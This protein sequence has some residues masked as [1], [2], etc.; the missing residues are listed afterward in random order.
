MK[1]KI[2]IAILAAGLGTRMKSRKAK[3][4][5]EAGGLALVEHVLRSAVSLAEPQNIVVV[6]G[7]QA[8]E[9][10]AL[11]SPYG[12]RFVRQLDQKG[13]GH[14][15]AMCS[16]ALAEHSGRLIVLYGDCPLLSASTLQKL[17]VRHQQSSAAATV[18]TTELADPTGYGRAILDENGDVN[19]IVEQR[20]A[21]DDQK[22]VRVIN[23]G[24]YCFNADILWRYLPRIEPNP[25]SG[26]YYL[27]DIVELLNHEGHRVA[28]FNHEDAAELLGINT[29]VEL[30]DVDAILN[31]RKARE[32]MLAG[33]TIRK[34]E[35]VTL[36]ARVIVGMD[37]VI[38]PFAQLLGNTTV[39]EN[40]RIGA[41]AVIRDSR[42]ADNVEIA[43]YT[44]VVTSV[45]ETGA[46]VG[47]FAR[48]RMEN[49]VEAGAHIGNF[50][51][52]KKTRFRAGAKAGHLAYL[53]DSDIGAE[54]NIGAGTITCNF[55]GARKHKTS[56]GDNAFIGS[57]STL[58]APVEIGEGAY[59]GAGSVITDGVPA[60]ALALGRSRQT[61][62]EGWA[63]ER[64]A[65]TASSAT[66]ASPSEIAA[67]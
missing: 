52:L 54:V 61:N 47:P 8:G 23:S 21:T 19:A 30:A 11:L 42:I 53:G 29:R 51:E 46:S 49:H 39:G 27:T 12:V 34:P 67:Q 35:T 33:V 2:S 6:T 22:S 24:I 48:L 66:K 5:H 16:E 59:V 45:V 26:E 14:A 63:A 58:V 9:V 50:V 38:E 36:D 15:L 44:F 1:D 32:L 3:V 37:C 7:H 64:R 60:D 31:A 56:I 55:D 62:K 65:R 28:S 20:A 57:N 10:E 18:I 4:L 43:P 13:T 41:G 17:L 25:A 40:C